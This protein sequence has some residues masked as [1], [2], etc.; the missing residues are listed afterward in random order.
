MTKY[1]NIRE[2]HE[3]VQSGDILQ[4]LITVVM[5]NDHTGFYYGVEQ[6]KI[7][8]GNG[9]HDIEDIYP[10]LFPRATVEWC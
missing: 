5:D 1:K 6:E 7:L 9:Y 10:L 3:A 8:D 4:S 2:L